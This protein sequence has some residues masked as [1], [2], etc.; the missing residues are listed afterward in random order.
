MSRQ[1]IRFHR[2]KSAQNDIDA[3]LEQGTNIWIENPGSK[4]SSRFQATNAIKSALNPLNF[5]NVIISYSLSIW[6][7]ISISQ[8]KKMLSLSSILVPPSLYIMLSSFFSH[9]HTFL[10]FARKIIFEEL[11]KFSDGSREILFS[12]ADYKALDKTASRNESMED[13]KHNRWH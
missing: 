6:L 2:P 8:H 13:E 3:L 7:C 9:L 5:V 4:L 1:V 12:F 10:S 11:H